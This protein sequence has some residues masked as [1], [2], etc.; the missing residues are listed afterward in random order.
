MPLY[1]YGTDLTGGR[2]ERGARSLAR[3]S[4]V[5]WTRIV[6]DPEASHLDPVSAAPGRNRFL[7]TVVPFLRR[8]GRD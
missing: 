1:A 8:L 4:D 2:V 7:E 5:P 6:R 3:G